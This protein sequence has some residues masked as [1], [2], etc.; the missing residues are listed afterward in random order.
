MGHAT[1]AAFAA[2]GALVVGCDIGVDRAQETT[3]LVVASGAGMVLMQA[4]HLADP[5]DCGAL[6]ERAVRPAPHGR[7]SARP[8]IS[9]AALMTG[10]LSAAPGPPT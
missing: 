4:C 8:G 6:V 5:A 1:A 2:E 3:E 9:A 10:A 7:P